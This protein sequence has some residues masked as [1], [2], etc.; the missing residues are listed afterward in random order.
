MRA[1]W[2]DGGTEAV[3]V[4]TATPF[5]APGQVWRTFWD[6]STKRESL[7]LP[8]R[9]DVTVSYTDSSGAAHSSRA[10][11]DWDVFRQRD[12]ITEKTM[13]NVA[14]SLESIDRTFKTAVGRDQV[15][16]VAVYS[17]RQLDQDRAE[18]RAE[19]KRRTEALVADATDTQVGPQSE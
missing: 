17:G 1:A 10:V 2:E 11:L 16:R 6:I 14:A 12:W 3:Q 18:S 15:E 5:L 4:P 9:H 13:H 8:D 7:D 19:K